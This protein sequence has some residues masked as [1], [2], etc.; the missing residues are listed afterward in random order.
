MAF[1]ILGDEWVEVNKR[2]SWMAGD[3]PK[4]LAGGLTCVAALLNFFGRWPKAM[5]AIAVV[6]AILLCWL[7]G[8]GIRALFQRLSGKRADQR[9]VTMEYPKLVQLFERLKQFTTRENTRGFRHMLYNASS[10]RVDVVDQILGSDFIEGW[11]CCFETML[12]EDCASLTEFLARCG[13][14]TP[15]VREF[16]SNYVIKTQKAVE[17]SVAVPEHNLDDFEDF[18]ERF[19]I[20]LN[21]VEQ[22]AE[23]IVRQIEVRVPHEIFLRYAPQRSF[24]RAKS[25]KRKAAMTAGSVTAAP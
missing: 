9:F 14:F 15:L 4:V 1:T 22:W 24:E 20:Y 23:S 25:F 7:M 13:H 18:R 19:G 8:S 21:D 11:M 2:K 10:Y 12:H 17:K 16:N 5:W 3:G 6:V